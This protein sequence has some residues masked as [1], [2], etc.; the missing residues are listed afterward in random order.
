MPVILRRT[1]SNGR[2][3]MCEDE[4]MKHR[5]AGLRNLFSI[6]AM[7]HWTRVREKDVIY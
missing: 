5:T 2:Q 4:V 6:L 7:Y 1:S 3:D